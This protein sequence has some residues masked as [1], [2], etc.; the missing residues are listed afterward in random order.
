M[1]CP[2][3]F[4]LGPPKDGNFGLSFA[5]LRENGELEPRTRKPSSTRSRME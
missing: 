5:V 4:N 3:D 2:L 1:Y